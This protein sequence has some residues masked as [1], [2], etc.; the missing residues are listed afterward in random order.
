MTVLMA[1]AAA[2]GAFVSLV[3]FVIEIVLFTVVRDRIRSAGYPAELGN[4]NWLVV[5]AVVALFIGFCTSLCG[6]FGRYSSGRFAGEKVSADA[7]LTAVLTAVLM[8][9]IKPS[10]TSQPLLIRPD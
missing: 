1:L 7:V 9:S 4:A 5:G 10:S 2:L 3:V 6:A 8:S